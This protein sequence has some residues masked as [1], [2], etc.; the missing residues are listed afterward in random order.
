MVRSKLHACNLDIHRRGVD[1]L[2]QCQ[3]HI[4]TIHA[5][6]AGQVE[7]VL[8]HLDV[9]VVFLQVDLLRQVTGCIHVGSLQVLRIRNLTVANQVIDSP[10][11]E[12][13]FH[14]TDVATRIVGIALAHAFIDAV[15]SIN[16][17]PLELHAHHDGEAQGTPFHTSLALETLCCGALDLVDGQ[18]VLP[19][20]DNLVPQSTCSIVGRLEVID[21]DLAGTLEVFFRQMLRHRQIH[22]VD[23]VGGERHLVAVDALGFHTQNDVVTEIHNLLDVFPRNGHAIV[24]IFFYLLAEDGLHSQRS[25]LVRHLSAVEELNRIGELQRVRFLTRTAEVIDTVPLHV[26]V[27][28]HEQL[29]DNPWIREV[30]SRNLGHAVGVFLRRVDGSLDVTEAEN[31]FNVIFLILFL[32]FVILFIVLILLFIVIHLIRGLDAE[33]FQVAA[34]VVLNLQIGNLTAGLVLVHSLHPSDIG[35]IRI[36]VADVILRDNALRLCELGSFIERSTFAHCIIGILHRKH[37]DHGEVVLECGG[38]GVTNYHGR[39]PREDGR[40]R[41]YVRDVTVILAEVQI[42]GRKEFWCL[43][44]VADIEETDAILGATCSLRR[45]VGGLVPLICRQMHLVQSFGQQTEGTVGVIRE[46]VLR[47]IHLAQGYVFEHLVHLDQRELIDALGRDG[48]RAGWL[49]LGRSRDRK[50]VVRHRLVNLEA[51]IDILNFVGQVRQGD[52]EVGSGVEDI[53]E[54]L[55]RQ[56][57]LDRRHRDHHFLSHTCGKRGTEGENLNEEEKEQPHSPA[58]SSRRN[59]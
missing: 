2:R 18:L 50:T 6:L 29:T 24:L 15:I 38:R 22:H 36:H 52:I 11:A 28:V 30:G 3:R 10:V 34:A 23:G 41:I 46:E 54:D 21:G 56:Y 39:S 58:S 59:T 19:Y 7:Q 44:I 57:L 43:S 14:T 35:T 45:G 5:A 12:Q 40:Q 25:S 8:A 1:V 32:F 51:K 31:T 33:E 47:S 37:L 20:I 48:I 42:H 49:A 26:D 4:Q 55:G 16:L 9:A 17:Q 27:L 53:E 13:L